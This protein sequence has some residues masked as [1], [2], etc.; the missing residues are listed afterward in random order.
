VIYFGR[1][2]KMI[3]I[4]P[5]VILTSYDLS[6]A[7]LSFGVKSLLREVGPLEVAA[8]SLTFVG[9]CCVARRWSITVDKRNFRRRGYL[10]HDA[11]GAKFLSRTSELALAHFR[12]SLSIST[13][14]FLDVSS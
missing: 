14:R 1:P 5:Y 3:S 6:K 10:L 12:P 8:T 9:I 7:T 13:L 2:V 11:I 4:C